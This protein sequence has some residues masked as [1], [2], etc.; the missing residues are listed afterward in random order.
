MRKL[1]LPS[2]TR[3][4]PHPAPCKSHAQGD[5]KDCLDTPTECGRSASFLLPQKGQ[6]RGR[7]ACLR[8]HPLRS[9]SLL[10]VILQVHHNGLISAPPRAALRTAAARVSSLRRRPAALLREARPRH[11]KGLQWGALPRERKKRLG[12]EGL[13]KVQGWRQPRTSRK[14]GSPTGQGK[15]SVA[16]REGA[17]P[18]PWGG[19][20]ARASGRSGRG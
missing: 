6:C 16:G 10:G 15:S 8:L 13:P 18:K 12:A 17:E 20:G 19:R 14:R 9:V 7:N 11:R 3:A 2:T 1:P 4:S 5:K